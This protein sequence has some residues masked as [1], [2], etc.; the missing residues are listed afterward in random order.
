MIFAKTASY[1]HSDLLLLKNL[2]AINKTKKPI[3]RIKIILKPK[4]F[5]SIFLEKTISK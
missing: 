2:L 3:T 4:I 5:P 1:I